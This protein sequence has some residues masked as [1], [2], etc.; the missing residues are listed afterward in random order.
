V[1]AVEPVA[2]VAF[3][4]FAG[5]VYLTFLAV[6]CTSCQAHNGSDVNQ[7]LGTQGQGHNGSS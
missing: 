4:A 3:V 7:G 2:V 6:L 5:T 1:S